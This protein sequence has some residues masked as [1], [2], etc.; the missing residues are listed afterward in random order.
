MIRVLA[1]C[2]LASVVAA[3]P[4]TRDKLPLI[5]GLY[6]DQRRALATALERA[7]NDEAKQRAAL[8]EVGVDPGVA[9]R[10]FE[11]VSGPLLVE[12]YS[13][14]VVLKAP[15]LTAKQKEIFAHLHPAALAAQWALMIQRYRVMKNKPQNTPESRAL[16]ESFDQQ[17]RLIEK[18]YW[19]I[20][21]YVLTANQRTA[22]HKLLPNAYRRPPNLLGHLYLLPGL[23]ASQASR[24]RALAEE[25]QSESAPERAEVARLRNKLADRSLTPELRRELQR[26]LVAATDREAELRKA[27]SPLSKKVLTAAQLAHLDAQPPLLAPFERRQAPLQVLAQAGLKPDHRARITKR[28]DELKQKLDARRKELEA[29]AKKL[30]ETETGGDSPQAMTM[31]MMAQNYRGDEIVAMDELGHFAVIE[32]LD[33]AQLLGWVISPR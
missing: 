25:Y 20:V 18:R 32:V 8:L 3:A 7:G 30:R 21:G 28:Q 6:P 5:P 13:H 19:R 1:L 2:A 15:D 29:K 10:L 4:V 23:T 22:I 11:V 14:G 27:L 16:R 17:V 12:R 33:K 31:N 26:K 24:L 9:D